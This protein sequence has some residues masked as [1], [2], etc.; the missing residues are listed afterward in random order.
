[1]LS[2]ALFIAFWVVLALIVFF[3][4]GGGGRGGESIWTQTSRG[5]RALGLVMVAIYV[6]FGIALPVIFL[7]GNHSNANAQVGGITLTRAERD[8]REIFGQK[9]GFCHTLAAANTVGK[10]GPNLDVLKPPYTLVLSTIQNGC[11]QNPPSPSAPT[12][13]LGEGNMPSGVVQGRQ[14]QDVASFVAKVAGR[15]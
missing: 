2:V 13:C 11:L 3:V 4:A 15:E 5:R 8:G 10:V 14:A 1:M 7:T 12:A 6:A 9:C